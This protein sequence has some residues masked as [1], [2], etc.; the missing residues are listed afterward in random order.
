MT[1]H[2]ADLEAEKMDVMEM[3][4]QLLISTWVGSDN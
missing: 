2:M 1:F 3:Y 4:C